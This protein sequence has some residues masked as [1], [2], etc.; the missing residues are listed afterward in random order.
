MLRKNDY[1]DV[2]YFLLILFPIYQ[3]VEIDNVT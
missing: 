1:E 3:V 2:N